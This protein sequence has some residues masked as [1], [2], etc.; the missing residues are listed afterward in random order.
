MKI[1][2]PNLEILEVPADRIYLDTKPLDHYSTYLNTF[3][4][5]FDNG[6]KFNQ[7]LIGFLVIK[8]GEETNIHDLQTVVTNLSS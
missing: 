2:S 4:T 5:I 7:E 3:G 1:T 8:L 6:E